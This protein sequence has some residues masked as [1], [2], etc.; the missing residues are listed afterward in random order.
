MICDSKPS[1]MKVL[2]TGS[3]DEYYQTINTW[4][5]IVEEKNKSVREMSSD[6]SEPKKGGQRK[7]F[8]PKANT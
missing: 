5:R 6:D 4:I 2:E 3:I 1:E 7:K 8:Q